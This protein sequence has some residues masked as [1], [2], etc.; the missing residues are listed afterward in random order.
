MM[1]GEDRA[2]GGN[3]DWNGVASNRRLVTCVTKTRYRNQRGECIG[4]VR[5]PP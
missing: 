2:C 5:L 4:L 1:H 3:H